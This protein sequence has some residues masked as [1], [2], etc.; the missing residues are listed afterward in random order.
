M[1]STSEP[2][3]R[4]WRHEQPEKFTPGEVATLALMGLGYAVLGASLLLATMLFF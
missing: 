4:S 2:T 3:L 1:K